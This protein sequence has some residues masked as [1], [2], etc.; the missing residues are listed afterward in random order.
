MLAGAGGGAGLSSGPPP[1]EPPELEGG[2][3]GKSEHC[4]GLPRARQS[5]FDSQQ[6]GSPCWRRWILGGALCSATILAPPGAQPSWGIPASPRRRW[7]PGVRF[8]HGAG[9]GIAASGF[10]LGQGRGEGGRSGM[11]RGCRLATDLPRG[12]LASPAFL[13][14]APLSRSQVSLLLHLQLFSLH[15]VSLVSSS[16]KPSLG[17]SFSPSCHLC[18]SPVFLLQFVFPNLDWLSFS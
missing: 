17:L 5:I 10:V 4:A 7:G 18:L 15:S 2:R 8:V 13:S 9:G 11:L 16:F 3:F 12:V 6:L 1:G 14:E